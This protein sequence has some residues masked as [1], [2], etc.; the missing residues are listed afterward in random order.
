MFD[1]TPKEQTIKN[2]R[3]GLVQP[4][5]NI[6]PLLNFE[7]DVLKKPLVFAD[8]DFVS[9]WVNNGFYFSS[10]S[11]AYDFLAQLLELQTQKCLGSLAVSEKKLL[12]LLIDNGI[13]FISTENI[14]ETI[15]CTCQKLENISNAICLSSEIQALK[16]IEKAK[17][18]VFF[19]KNTQVESPSSN[20]FFSELAIKNDMRV[21]L[22]FDYFKQHQAV[23]LFM[24]E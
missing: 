9:N 10:C 14:E 24:A 15:V 4:L 22:N 18:I 12:D 13:D 17:N 6:Y 20:V 1:I 2:V 11:N 3:K 16:G 19:A 23:Y 21:L 5:P 8:E 7:S